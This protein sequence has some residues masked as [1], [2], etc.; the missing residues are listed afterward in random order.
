M[1]PLQAYVPVRMATLITIPKFVLNVYI[2]VRHVLI[3]QVNVYP[4]KTI[5]NRIGL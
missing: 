5:A 2:L 4:V 3:L 1:I